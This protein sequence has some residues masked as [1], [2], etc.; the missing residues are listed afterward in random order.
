MS[1]LDAFWHIANL[2]LPAWAVAA[3]LACAVKLL[4]RRDLAALTWR[5]LAL[6][7]AAGGS[8]AVIAALVITGHDGKMIG[9][10]LMLAGISLAQWLLMIRR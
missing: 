9:Y 1:P 4:W 10:G 5:R 6:W 7:G 3:L 2:F 8:V